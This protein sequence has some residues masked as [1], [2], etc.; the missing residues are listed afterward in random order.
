MNR[1]DYKKVA[2]YCL[3]KYPKHCERVIKK[4]DD[5]LQNKFIFDMPWDMER[6]EEIVDFGDKID[7]YFTL[8]G[9]FEF[10]YQLN[11]HSYLIYLLQSYYLTGNEKYVKKTCAVLKDWIDNV[12]KDKGELSPWRLLEVGFRGESWVQ[13]ALYLENTPFYN[14]PFKNKFINSMKEHIDVFYNAHSSFQI[15]SN[16][17]II[18]NSGLFSLSCYLN[19]I[20]MAEIAFERLC[21][22]SLFQITADGLHWEQ[23]SGYHNA[24]L[25]SLLNVM[26]VAKRY[27]FKISEDFIKRIKSLAKVNERWIKPN[28]RHPLLG[29]SDNN[30]IRDIM[31]RCAYLFESGSFKYLGFSSL[32]YD[33]LWLFGIK[34]EEKYKQIMPQEPSRLNSYLYDSGN[35]ILRSDWSR[36]ANYLLF[37][38]GYTGGGHAHGDKLHFELCLSGRDVLVDAGRYTYKNIKER[39]DIKN[40]P[41]HNTATVDEKLFLEAVDAWEIENPAIS[42]Q[43]P[44]YENKDCVL[45]GGGHLG[46]INDGVYIGRQILWIKPHIYIVIDSFYSRNTHKYNRYF[47]FSPDGKVSV[48]GNTAIYTDSVGEVNLYFQ[49]HGRIETSPSIYSPNY[50]KLCENEAVVHSFEEKGNAFAL[51]VISENRGENPV[52][53]EY[54]LA[55]LNGTNRP[56]TKEMGEGIVIKTKLAEYT[57][58]IAHKEIKQ[59]FLCNNKKATGSIVVYK[60]NDIIFNRW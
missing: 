12:L 45:L 48:R 42:V 13:I 11:R 46:Y 43:N 57:V 54:I 36:N 60:D 27:D 40:A 4:A 55:L 6:T 44:V 26:N 1:I 22:A 10:L 37:H 21:E 3:R 38:N 34:G 32:D 58:C 50:N 16:W 31:S 2:E 20:D 30:D 41:A 39:Q 15:S 53:V 8:N 56:I 47:H 24:V 59:V 9:D 28:H 49:K 17:G 33:S 25:I 29:D 52:S 19:K 18:Q 35:Y 14:D 5:I 7:W 51:T 23:S